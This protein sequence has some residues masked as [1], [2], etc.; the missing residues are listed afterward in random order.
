MASLR[1][2]PRRGLASCIARCTAG[3]VLLLVH[4]H[5]LHGKYLM[6]GVPFAWSF[7][8]CSTPLLRATSFLPG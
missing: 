8:L 7:A 2:M 6:R 1:C 5:V 3:A 4:V